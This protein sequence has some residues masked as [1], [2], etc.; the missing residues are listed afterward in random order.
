MNLNV[1]GIICSANWGPLTLGVWTRHT[2]PSISLAFVHMEMEEYPWFGMVKMPTPNPQIALDGYAMEMFGFK[3]WLLTAKNGK[4]EALWYPRIQD[5]LQK[6]VLLPRD[7]RWIK[8]NLKSVQISGWCWLVVWNMFYFPHILGIS[9]SQL[10]HIF[11]RGRYT[12]NQWCVFIFSYF[13]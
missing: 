9:S 4:A 13:S 8:E 3:W 12:T 6:W 11:Q 1:S 5:W 2:A 10:T 7:S